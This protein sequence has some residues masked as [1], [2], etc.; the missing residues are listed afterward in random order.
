MKPYKKLTI[1]AVCITFVGLATVWA[2]P[3]LK[4]ITQARLRP[5]GT[6]ITVKQAN[7]VT[8]K[9]ANGVPVSYYY[10]GGGEVVTPTVNGAFTATKLGTFS[11]TSFPN[12]YPCLVDRRAWKASHSNQGHDWYRY[13]STDHGAGGIY[14]QVANGDPTV[15]ANWKS[16]NAALAAGE[17]AYLTTKPS[18]NPIYADTTEGTG[19]ETP[20]VNIIGGEWI[21]TYHNKDIVGDPSPDGQKTMMALSTD[22][23]NFTRQDQS[24]S[25][26]ILPVA[27]DEPGGGHTGYF[28][29]WPNTLSYWPYA[30]V[31]RSLYGGGGQ[32]Y[33]AMWGSNNGKTW[34]RAALYDSAI[35][36]GLPA[37]YTIT[38]PSNCFR[39]LSDGSL[40]G[41]VECGG[42]GTQGAARDAAI[43][44]F[45][46]APDGVTPISQGR[47]VVAKGGTGEGDESQAANPQI[48][49]YGS[50]NVLNYQG[51]TI[52]NE[53]TTMMGTVAFA[54]TSPVPAAR[55]YDGSYTVENTVNFKAVSALPS[56]LTQA[57][58]TGPVT[59]SFN[60]TNGITS[61]GNQSGRRFELQGTTPLNLADYSMVE[62]YC[63]GV[64]IKGGSFTIGF[65]NAATASVG[66]EAIAG[67]CASSTSYN[68]NAVVRQANAYLSQTV[69]PIQIDQPTT[70]DV[71]IRY[72]PQA[73][74]MEI[75]SFSRSI[76]YTQTVS[77]SFSNSI[78]LV[79]KVGHTSD[80][81]SIGK[82]TI[83]TKSTT[84]P[85]VSY[86]TIDGQRALID[87]GNA[88]IN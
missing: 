7:G 53:N 23:V 30:Y 11:P 20:W 65:A 38:W 42:V 70:Q 75:L 21:L 37:G 77:S 10:S 22:G 19:S 40:L 17:F 34:T 39:T 26:I 49:P 27:L 55:T 71:G 56:F 24:G 18:A 3:L 81:I 86:G 46:L 44:E 1:L 32:G 41:L 31:G 84:P 13:T 58:T 57:F 66:T 79:P 12:Y 52:A 28:V 2:G 35:P 87:G 16:Y 6:L 76:A 60:S 47:L 33:V 54:E 69:T 45:V 80:N 50:V 73:K 85:T 62:I 9:Q 5:V 4:A 15:L 68:L 61:A 59:Y 64:T 78:S 83:R 51:V 63:E 8:V 36:E 82:V 67:L 43:Y 88:T 72:Y 74:R 48:V 29:W 25:A 14:L